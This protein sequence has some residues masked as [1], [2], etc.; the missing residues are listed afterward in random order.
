M[1][2]KRLFDGLS[3]SE[4]LHASRS[5]PTGQFRSGYFLATLTFEG[6]S[7][8]L[9][10]GLDG[11]ETSEWLHAVW[12]VPSCLPWSQY[13]LAISIFPEWSEI[14]ISRFWNVNCFSDLGRKA[15]SYS[16]GNRSLILS[17][18]H[19]TIAAHHVGMG[20]AHSDLQKLNFLLKNTSAMLHEIQ[21]LSW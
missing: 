10:L 21:R 9:R 3:M 18:W 17:P 13:L 15:N 2:S 4:L 14:V 11:P 8:T 6:C 7:D 5:V 12:G 20:N 19:C 16:I 1:V